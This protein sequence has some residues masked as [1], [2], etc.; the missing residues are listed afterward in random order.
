MARTDGPPPTI[1]IVD[2]DAI[3]RRVLRALLGR[4]ER[5]VH[6]ASDAAGALE[7]LA[8]E[9][10][11]V[12]ITD[13]HMPEIDG[14]ELVRRMRATARGR[15]V[16]AILLTGDRQGKIEALEIGADAFLSKPV[17]PGELE[18]QLRV[19]ARL[20]DLHAQAAAQLESLAEVNADLE[21]ELRRRQ[22]AE[23]QI[24]REQRQMRAIYQ[25]ALDAIIVVGEGGRLLE[26]NPAAE[27][28]FSV[29]GEALRDQPLIELEALPA[30]LR[31]L[32]YAFDDRSTSQLQELEL[33]HDGRQLVLDV[34]LTAHAEDGPLLRTAFVRD[35]TERRRAELALASARQHEVEIASRIQ[36]LLLFGQ[37]PAYMPGLE[38]AALTLPSQEV[39][40]DFYDYFRHAPHLFDVVVGDVMGKGI[41]AALLGAATKTQLLHAIGQIVASAG[42]GDPDPEA[43]VNQTHLR[44]GATLVELGS[45]VT[46]CY[47]RCDLKQGRLTY[48]DAGHT[49]TIHFGADGQLSLL[50]GDNLPLGVLPDEK[51]VACSV[52][53]AAGDVVVLYSDGVTEAENPAG[54]MF[55]E[56]RLA[57]LVRTRA[58]LSTSAELI[59]EIHDAVIAFADGCELRDDLTLLV[60]R[61]GYREEAQRATI[62][63]HRET[64]VIADLSELG[65]ICAMVRQTVEEQIPE[66][67]PEALLMLELA[68][69]EVASNIIRH[70]Y[71]GR[72]DE[73]IQLAVTIVAREVQVRMLHRGEP[74]NPELA[75]ERPA[76]EGPSEGGMGLYMIDQS[77]D[78]VRYGARP[79]GRSQVLL[80]KHIPRES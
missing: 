27:R 77:V 24:R 76:F 15:Y 14:L 66:C 79:D 47:M 72:R 21:S 49:K 26:F 17:D 13:W 73:R 23:A 35:V 53:L 4:R 32:I 51:Y 5:S 29:S 50:E 70:A 31:E 54:E 62:T 34:V 28:M 6:E 55:G 20:R 57:T 10:V 36:R 43:I 22:Q 65:A 12:L 1:L 37:P 74:M 71:A 33:E 78:E 3:A 8:R 16:Y 9:T 63:C 39:D 46:L 18:S 69:N 45:F 67:D 38:L 11:D 44:I 68:V 64:E 80:R 59:N 56:E 30:P 41:P 52:P 60:I 2:D 58:E 19:A 61:A 25:T 75:A 42:G 40:G 7:I 48:V